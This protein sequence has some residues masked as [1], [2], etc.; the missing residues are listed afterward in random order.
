ML[1]KEKNKSE[2]RLKNINRFKKYTNAI[3]LLWILI[4]S[5]SMI[6]NVYFEINHTERL[7]RDFARGQFQKD[8]AIR[9]WASKHG[10]I[11]VPKNERTPGNPY[12]SHITDRDIIKNGKDTL[13]LMN[14]AYIIRQMFDE[15][16]EDYGVNGRIVSTKA[17]NPNN[18]PDEWERRALLDFEKGTEEVFEYSE[19]NGKK[20]L[21]LIKPMMTEK[22]CLKCHG[23]QGYKVGDVR[24]G[25]GVSIL[26][27]PYTA[28][29][30]ANNFR[31]VLAHVIFMVIGFVGIKYYSSKLSYSIEKQIEVEKELHSQEEKT[32]FVLESINDG[33]WEIDLRTGKSKLSPKL[34]EMFGY[35]VE[36]LLPLNRDIVTKNIH[37]DDIINYNLAFDEHLSGKKDFY[38]AE[39]RVKHKNGSWI[40]I[41]D[42]GKIIE[43]DENNNPLKII[44]ITSDITERKNTELEI[45]ESEKKLSQIFNGTHETIGLIAINSDGKFILE[46]LN[47]NMI[48]EM[49][50]IGKIINPEEVKNM[51]YEKFLTEKLHYEKEKCSEIIDLYKK[52]AQ[53]KET[54]VY[55][56][57]SSI[58]GGVLISENT[59]TPILDDNGNCIKILVVGRDI[60]EK[61]ELEN[62]LLTVYSS[63]ENSVTGFAIVGKD[64]KLTYVN[65]SYVKMWGYSSKKE[66]QN[67]GFADQCVDPAI[68]AIILNEADEKGEVKIEFKAKKKDG[69][70]FITLMSVSSNYDHLGNEIYPLF[71]TDITALRENE[72][73]LKE[74][75]ELYR[76]VSEY[77][78]NWEYWNDPERNPI[79][80]SPACEKI[81]GYSVDEFMKDKY[82]F[83][84]IVINEDMPIWERHSQRTSGTDIVEKEIRFRIKNKKGEIHWIGHICRPII[85]DNGI[86]IGYR[87]TNRNITEE[88]KKD[89]I[90]KD[91]L[92]ENKRKVEELKQLY[93][94]IADE[95]NA[96]L[97]LMEDLQLEVVERKE[98]EKLLVESETKF[99]TILETAQDGFWITSMDGEILAVNEA[100]ISMSG[101]TREELL[102]MGIA[103]AEAIEST[104][105][106]KEH[107]NNIVKNGSD[108]FESVHIRKDGSRFHVEISVKY[109][110]LDGG[111]CVVFIKDIT[112]RKKADEELLNSEK[113]YRHLSKL[114]VSMSDNL[115]DMLW[116]KDLNK[117]YIFINNAMARNLLNAKD[118]REPIGKNDMFFAK[119][120]REQHPENLTY[121]TFGE[122]CMDS[123]DVV[124]KTKKG[125]QFDEWGNVKGE[126]IYLD[127]YKAPLYDEEGMLIGTV[128]SARNVT[129]EREI[130]AKLNESEAKNK[131]VVKA[132]PDLLFEFDQ[133]GKLLIYYSMDTVF[134]LPSF[135]KL[136]NKNINE[137]SNRDVAKLLIDNIKEVFLSGEMREFELEYPIENII[138]Y[139]EVR[140]VQKDSESVIAFVRN[141]T[142]KK[143]TEL[144]LI[145]SEKRFRRILEDMPL[146]GVILN[147][148]AS[149]AYCNKYL[150]EFT[151]WTSEELYSKNWMDTFIPEK[152]G[153][154]IN[155]IF[156]NDT[157]SI[158][159]LDKN[160]NEILLK[161]GETRIIQWSN[162]TLDQENDKIQIASIGRDITEEYIE[163]N[164][165]SQLISFYEEMNNCNE[166]EEEL[167]IIL[168][169]SINIIGM[170]GGAIYLVHEIKKEL[171]IA[172]SNNIS[173]EF[174]ES[175]NPLSIN[176]PQIE[177]ITVNDNPVFRD[178]DK[179]KA[180]G[181]GTALKENLKSSIFIPILKSDKFV[182]LLIV[183]SYKKEN[184]NAYQK[185]ITNKLKNEINKFTVGI[186][187][188]AKINENRKRYEML[189]NSM[190]NGFALHEMI[191][192]KNGDPA[193]Y[194]FIDVNPAFER[195]TG[196]KRENIINK[197][198]LEVMPNT[199]KYWI[200][201]YG[202][203]VKTGHPK[204]FEN[205]SRE[206][207]KFF[208]VLA[209]SPQ[210]GQFATIVQDSTEKIMSREHLKKLSRAVEQSQ[211]AIVITSV[212]GL[213]EYV[214]PK[215]CK[216]TGYSEE[217]LIGRNPNILKSGM[218]ESKFYEEMWSTIKSG[219]EWS[220]VF[221]NKIKDGSL[222]WESAII[223][224][225]SNAK[226]EITHFVAVKED[227]TERIETEKELKNYRESLENLVDRRT[228]ELVGTNELLKIEIDKSQY[229]EQQALTA[230]EKQS[231]LSEMKTKFISTTS[232]EFKTPLT[233][234]LSSIE[235]VEL[236]VN[237]NE[238]EKMHKHVDRIKRSIDFLNGLINDVLLLNKTETGNI[239]YEPEI[240]NIKDL[241]REVF[242]DIKVSNNYKHKMEFTDS[243]N[244]RENF[245]LDKRL[246]TLILTNLL[247][248]AVKYSPGGGEIVLKLWIEREQLFFEIKDHGIGISDLDLKNISE[249]FYRGENIQN[250]P[251][252]G[253]GLS[254]V[255][256][257]IELHDGQMTVKSELGEGTRF[258]VILPIKEK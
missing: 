205:N 134:P 54:I 197:T 67:V 132:I 123:D 227:I 164:F 100:Y 22:S 90:L 72:R 4:V 151:G 139:F 213:I 166:F 142:D 243:L 192:D 221:R 145:T 185:I 97:N 238:T 147:N 182:A 226:G 222:I 62:K 250:I 163:S 69:S 253:L 3:I 103:D 86:F 234:I 140:M 167:R 201:T 76:T 27:E 1:K 239:K 190:L 171:Y 193:D 93:K 199:E 37:P 51:D 254:I 152:I 17:F 120:E 128:G 87:G 209:Y 236:F 135:K 30:N 55:V 64:G 92:N 102:K 208:E 241:A 13:T 88:V 224:P 217:E 63:I 117:N 212:D 53:T 251:G 188:E 175:V 138:Y 106:V 159:F 155:K 77:T 52:V 127:V 176:D 78:Y 109:V 50:K 23:E 113:R 148:D 110:N 245:L 5:I 143:K 204:T 183:G 170:D 45:L 44:G 20:Y 48:I 216:V 231:E 81:T 195:L 160:I 232:H 70:A 252:S 94:K 21:R 249:Q 133:Y 85:D 168:D 181:F 105:S 83:K 71:S 130:S 180:N 177:Q 124:L 207:G 75:E 242:S 191:Y 165:A 161:N 58:S 225:I 179:I 125:T 96:S 169:N 38:S 233:T 35:T 240:L 214:N 57:D 228:K 189:F 26:M 32:G 104:A 202:E 2:N 42:R 61:Y 198:V 144:K 187:A 65:D 107:L 173:E 121:H 235:L 200:D 126:F 158:E 210:E 122:L 136:V 150:C 101:Y 49:S 33:T 60:T 203:I 14:P 82:L 74:A 8:Q 149:I 34:G 56:R 59:V 15:Y 248:N 84:K 206:L 237:K 99:R 68:P 220:G 12:L 129:K 116:A 66:I 24:G 153:D 114:F 131:A 230:L 108:S 258:S 73:K 146:I 141:I 218:H 157:N 115:E 244:G 80:V 10:G 196:L 79:F 36:E 172:V 25:V 112:E 43:R 256:K 118:T 119:R 46:E 194:R 11:Y 211:V 137:I 9:F 257:A 184:F 29:M 95:Q 16:P 174:L 229:D 111:I 19:I 162:S 39:F 156:N 89:I 178:F 6:W 247:S 7:V 41:L 47:R 98:R 40:W 91:A 246:I 186:I 154:Y 223:S 255:K 31:I 219:N 28:S 18:L 215:Y